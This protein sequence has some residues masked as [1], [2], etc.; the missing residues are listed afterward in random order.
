MKLFKA[1]EFWRKHVEKRHAEFFERV[2]F[3]VQLVN[4]YVVDPAHIAPSRSD[5]NSNG[6]FPLGNNGHSGTPRNFQLNPQ[7]MN[8][9]MSMGMGFNP[10][11]MPPNAMISPQMLAAASIAGAMPSWPGMPNMTSVQGGV[12][13]I[14]NHGG[15]GGHLNGGF[16]R[17]PYARHDGRGRMPSFGAGPGARGGAMAMMGMPDGVEGGSGAIG[18]LGAVQGRTLRTYEDLD[19]PGEKKVEELDY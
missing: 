2:R 14:R 12:G 1:P 16:G 9:P 4:T 8:V 3:D 7:G 17:N 19:V 11:N 6:H 5:A 13:P 15:R 10:A 18:P